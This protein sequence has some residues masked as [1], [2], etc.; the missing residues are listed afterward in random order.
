M[1]LRVLR[2]FLAV[3][4][5]GTVSGAAD[6]LHLSQPSL[7]RQ[8][9]GLEKELGKTLFLRGS[10]RIV[11]TEEGMLLRR[12]AEEIL[13]LVEKTESEFLDAQ[14]GIGGDVH[15]GGGESC[16]M[17]LI[18]GLAEELRREYPEVR[19]RLFSGNAEAV[20]DRLDKGLLDFGVLIDPADLT[21]YDAM[22]LPDADVWGV[23]MR[24]DCPLAD[25][26]AV[27]PEDLWDLPLILSSQAMEGRE[28]SGWLGREYEE[29]NVAAT[30]TLLYNASL[31]VKEGVGCALCLD[32]I[33]N[34]SGDSPF[35][36]RPLDPR[37]EARL[38]VVRKKYQVLSKAARTFWER[39]QERLQARRAAP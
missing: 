30:Y 20:T 38:N 18:A 15:I 12:R 35:V 17:R 36:F 14:G 33:L 13:G 2:Y 26:E 6:F 21:K 39:L 19:F 29:L 7:S 11:L 4:R 32:G 24:R 5:E 1:E 25:R 28:L 34:T 27:R 9:M 23:L 8:L 31:L 10:R 37:L 22:P 16:A 3:A